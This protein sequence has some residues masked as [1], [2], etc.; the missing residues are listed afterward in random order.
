MNAKCP[1]Q[2]AKPSRLEM[3]GI[4]ASCRKNL[5]QP[6]DIGTLEFDITALAVGGER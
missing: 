3:R 4:V 6:F 2:K 1:N 5:M